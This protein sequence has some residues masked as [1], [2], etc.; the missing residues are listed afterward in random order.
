M[1]DTNWEGRAVDVKQVDTITVAGTW[2]AGDTVTITC[3]GLDFIITIGTLVTTAQVATTISQAFN[4][5]A[6]TDTTASCTIPI[7]DGGAQAI[8]QF[9]EAV[10]TVSSSVVSLTARSTEG[11]PFTFT[12]TENTASTGTATLAASIV[13]HGRHEGDNADNFSAGAVLANNDNLSFPDGAIDLLYD[14]SFGVQLASIQ[15][16]RQ[17]TGKVG[18]AVTNADDSSLPYTEYRGLYA[19]TTNNSVT[20]TANLETG[21]QGQG[22]GRFKWNFGAGQCTVNVYGKGTRELTGVPCI[23][24][25]GTHASNEL[26]NLAG[27]VGVAFY[28]G[29]T[30]TFAVVRNGDGP[31]S[32]AHTTLGVGVTLSSA[33][34]TING[35]TLESNSAISAVNHYGGV[36]THKLGTITAHNCQ[37]GIGEARF[38]V[39]GAVT[40]TTQTIGPRGVVDLTAGTGTVTFTNAIQ[41][42]KGAQFI[43]PQGRSGNPVFVLNRCDPSD[44][45]IRLP[46]G[47]TITTS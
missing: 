46:P 19:V 28:Y 11:K 47:K 37:G 1:A 35:G 9:A 10:A 16:S 41:M 13:P 26:N 40:I 44:V 33:T 12:V 18:L 27:D 14:M 22:S 15:K 43:D 8:P 29:E 20:T 2:T 36:H 3:D 24:I 34:V 45:V 7:A 42:T 5:T 17:F 38:K 21:A 25:L 30:S 32:V 39:V 23:L 6:F 31:Q 4:G